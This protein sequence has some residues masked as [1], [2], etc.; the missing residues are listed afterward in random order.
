MEISSVQII[1][2]QNIPTGTNNKTPEGDAFSKVL[3]KIADVVDGE[4]MDL[5]AD[6]L[7][8]VEPMVEESEEEEEHLLFNPMNIPWM[9]MNIEKNVDSDQILG[10]TNP[11][12]VETID[13]DILTL[14]LSLVNGIGEVEDVNLVQPLI[15]EEGI[16]M[17]QEFSM[18]L[19]NEILLASDNTKT[20]INKVDV[21]EIS[22]E[23]MDKESIKSEST[24]SKSE[25]ISM[26][27]EIE[28]KEEIEATSLKDNKVKE[29]KNDEVDFMENH[30][31]RFRL[32]KG[33][34]NEIS[35]ESIPQR[36]IDFDEN[37]QRVNDT[38]IE[39]MDIR[40]DGEN[41]SIKVKLNPEEL[42]FVDVTLKMEEGK[43]VAR[44]LVE[45]EQ[46]R[47]LFNNHMNQLNDK[48][49]KQDINIEKV[50]IDLNLNSNNHSNS[51]N[52]QNNKNNP[53]K[54]NQGIISSNGIEPITIEEQAN[55]ISGGNGL[56]ILA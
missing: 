39:L 38:I 16:E 6:L 8:L 25:S 22:M 12:M 32:E 9:L 48:L 55:T 42:G 11:T 18:E 34:T 35:Q 31:Q 24:P 49:V 2:T 1:N 19:E 27:K 26:D 51:S 5:A 3:A 30:I 33:N 47:E 17:N 15:S 44:I 41:S 13:G 52:S 36:N 45:N 56:N 46:V 21:P 40:A 28:P 53:F 50:Q 4:E 10:D 54:S 7:D 43:L 23:N 20:D 14:D 37:I 29:T